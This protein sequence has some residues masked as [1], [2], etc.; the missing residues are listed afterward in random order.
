[1]PHATDGD[2]PPIQVL[3]YA[4]SELLRPTLAYALLPRLLDI[5]AQIEHIRQRVVDQSAALLKKVMKGEVVFREDD[6]DGNE[7]ENG[8]EKNGERTDWRKTLKT[9]GSAKG[10]ATHRKTY[11]RFVLELCKAV[12]VFSLGRRLWRSSC[13]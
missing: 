1:M 3:A 9:Y 8:G 6:G 10:A 13:G 5:L 2:Y 11:R 12:G 4:A 7:N